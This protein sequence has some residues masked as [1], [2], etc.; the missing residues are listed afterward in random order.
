MLREEKTTEAR[1]TRSY[2]LLGGWLLRYW[3]AYCRAAAPAARRGQVATP[4]TARILSLFTWAAGP[5]AGPGANATSENHTAPHDPTTG[6]GRATIRVTP[7]RSRIPDPGSSMGT[8]KRTKSTKGG[9]ER[10][11][12]C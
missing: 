11:L 8:T 7:G 1:R 4:P 2:W 5:A 9:E 3:L 6:T 12:K 10:S